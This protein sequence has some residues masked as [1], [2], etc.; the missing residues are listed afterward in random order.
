MRKVMLVATREYLAAV[1]SK[2]FLVSLVMMPIFMGGGLIAV[3]LLQGQV[4]IRDRRIA[5]VDRSGALAEALAQAAQQR[6]AKELRDGKTGKQVKQGDVI[7]YV[8]A[9]GVATGPHLDYRIKK[10]GKFIDPRKVDLPAADPVADAYRS[11]FESHRDQ[12]AVRLAQLSE[13]SAREIA[14]GSSSNP[15]VS[16][17]PER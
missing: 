13:R 5:V 17:S 14:L 10:N 7:G 4:D 1:R 11:Q 6:N 12:W 2:A 15:P 8:G 16:H 9:T 3:K